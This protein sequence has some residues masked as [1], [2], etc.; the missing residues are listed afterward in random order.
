MAEINGTE[1]GG[2]EIAVKVAIDS[3]DEA[4]AEINGTEIGG[5]EIAR[6]IAIDSP[7]KTDEEA[8]AGRCQQGFDALTQHQRF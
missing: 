3:P 7:D 2:L 8:R 6:K 4:V 1:I 5:R